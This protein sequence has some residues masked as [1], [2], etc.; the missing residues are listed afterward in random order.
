M[1]RDMD[2]TTIHTVCSKRA[3]KTLCV[4]LFLGDDMTIQ[5]VSKP[6]AAGKQAAI[7]LDGTIT[8]ADE[9]ET[10]KPGCS[11][12]EEAKKAKKANLLSR[13]AKGVPGLLKSELGID[14][15]GPGL[16]HDRKNVCLECPSGYYD[17][18]VCS[19][20]RGGC[21]C[22]LASKVTIGGEACPE[23]HW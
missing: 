14:Q 2:R 5:D 23:G 1:L 7:R 6:Y 22:F 12:C 3:N 13:L 9:P 17:F 4:E 20:E 11:S 8:Q 15:A 16:I 19:E 18:G 10:D 21:G